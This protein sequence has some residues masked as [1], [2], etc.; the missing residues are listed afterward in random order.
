MPKYPKQHRSYKKPLIIIAS[1]I[2]LLA[3]VFATLELTGIT[4]FMHKKH[5]PAVTANQNTKGEGPASNGQSNSNQNQSDDTN[6]GDGT[7]SSD[8]KTPNDETPS[9]KLEAP[10]GNFVSNHHPNLDGDPAPNKMQSSCVTNPGATCQIT[11]TKDGVT[12]SLPAKKTDAGGGV[13]WDWKLQDIGL[14]TGSW[15][16]QA[17][18]QLGTQTET[19]DDSIL[20]E[21]KE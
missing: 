18:A 20:L 6:T 12:K 16:I 3:G 9:T 8:N 5:A 19:A 7:W 15:K 10:T 13:Y 17:K 21:V 4:S 1:G 2:I 11:F 14:T